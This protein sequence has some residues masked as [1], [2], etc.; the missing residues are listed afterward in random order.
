[1]VLAYGEMGVKLTITGKGMQKKRA[2]KEKSLHSS[3]IPQSSIQ[4]QVEGK[5]RWSLL[6]LAHNQSVTQSTL[7]FM[8]QYMLQ[9]QHN[10]LAE[11]TLTYSY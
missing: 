5:V 4:L 3:F 1:M 11:H 10:S 9:K 6:S 2:D 7:A 8:Y